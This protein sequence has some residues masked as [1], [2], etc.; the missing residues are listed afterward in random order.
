MNLKR[1]FEENDGFGVLATA[2]GSGVVNAAVYAR[3]HV[4]ADDRVAFIMSDRLTHENLKSNPH[5]VYLF[6]VDPRE[7]GRPYEG[8]RLFLTCVEETNKRELID[9]LRQR[10]YSDPKKA[11]FMVTFKVDRSLPLVVSGAGEAVE[12]IEYV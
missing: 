9:P 11:S 5:A 6:R 1:L 7:G 2:D 8:V 3:P 4:F 10:T 12:E